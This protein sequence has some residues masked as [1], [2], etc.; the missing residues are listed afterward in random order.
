MTTDDNSPAYG[1]ISWAPD[2]KSARRLLEGDPESAHALTIEAG[3]AGRERDEAQTTL[4]E[5]VEHNRQ[6]TEI[7]VEHETFPDFRAQ[8]RE[9][10]GNRLL[11]DRQLKEARRITEQYR[12]EHDAGRRLPWEGL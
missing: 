3:R 5:C 12:D 4:A 1:S 10:L 11:S 9:R 6:L 2:Y 7:I 8:L